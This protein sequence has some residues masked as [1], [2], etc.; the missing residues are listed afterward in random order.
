MQLD[1]VDKGILFLCASWNY[2]IIIPSQFAEAL[3]L[4]A[5]ALG[6]V[7]ISMPTDHEA[8]VSIPGSAV[9]VLCSEKLFHEMYSLGASVFH[10]P[11]TCSVLCCPNEAS[12]LCWPQFRGGSQIVS[13]F[14]YVFLRNFPIPQ[15]CD[16]WKLENN[17]FFFVSS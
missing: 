14:P 13:V 6:S 16:K 3:L 1:M 2:L 9:V 11:F 8:P 10:Y 12:A 15:I 17:D 4:L 5:M 7:V